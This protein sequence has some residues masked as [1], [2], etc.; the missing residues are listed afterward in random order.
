MPPWMIPLGRLCDRKHSHTRLTGSHG[1]TSAVYPW[2]FAL[3]FGK[4]LQTAPRWLSLVKDGLQ[5][6]KIDSRGSSVSAAE[7]NGHWPNVPLAFL[8]GDLDEARRCRVCTNHKVIAP[9]RSNVT[10]DLQN[11]QKKRK[12]S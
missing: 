9:I 2:K 11:S 4:Q 8:A 10:S 6:R 3:S 1:L 5:V 7:F 12:N